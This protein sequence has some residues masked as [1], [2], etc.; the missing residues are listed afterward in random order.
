M[1]AMAANLLLNY[2]LRGSEPAQLLEAVRGAEEGRTVFE[3]ASH[4]GC[5]VCAAQWLA[6]L[7][8]RMSDT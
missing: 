3:P 7:N 8:R 1:A 5:G 6:E 2:V 4:A